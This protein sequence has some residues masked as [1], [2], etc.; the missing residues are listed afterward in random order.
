MFFT[1]SKIAWFV[2]NPGNFLLILLC[3]AFAMMTAAS[4]PRLVRCGRYIGG[5][6]VA[7]FLLIT[8]LPL[9]QWMLI[10]LE[11][12]FEARP[13]P[14]QVDG[15]IVLGG[16]LNE[17]ISAMRGQAELNGS[18][19][20]LVAL[21]KLARAYPYAKIVFTGGSGQLLSSSVPEAD[22]V[23]D[24]LEELR[25]IDRPSRFVF[26][27]KSRNTYE[28][29]IESRN[30]VSPKK[31]ETWLLVTSARHMPRAMGVFRQAGWPGLVAVPVDYQTTGNPGGGEA[32]LTSGLQE[33]SLAMKEWIGLAAYYATGRTNALFPARQ[34]R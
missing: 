2:L 25:V 26:E 17:D 11:S 4:R 27:N 14:G 23:K 9:G 19:D 29:A 34:M 28:N 8:L 1:I 15:V 6:V 18:A 3:V 10:P 30:L 16:V 21:F 12:R 32:S 20:R 7:A 24:L 22:L 31:N 5:F 13:L 33:L